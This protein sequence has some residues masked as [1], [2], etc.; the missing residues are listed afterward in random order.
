LYNTNN[1]GVATISQN[2][3]YHY[4]ISRTGGNIYAF[5]NG[6]LENVTANSY[7]ATNTGFYIGCQNGTGQFFT[8]YISN[9]RVI[10][11][12]GLYTANFAPPT[13]PLTPI[14]NT[15][16]LTNQ[17]AELEDTSPNYFNL[18]NTGT[19]LPSPQ[20]PFGNYSIFLNGTSQYLS[21]ASNATLALGSGNF[22]VE[23]WVYINY[24]NAAALPSTAAGIYD[25]R[26]GT[27]GAGVVQ[28]CLELNSTGYVWY[29]T[30]TS[31]IAS[32]TT[33]IGYQRW[34]HIAV[35]RNSGTTNM[36]LDGVQVGSSY[37]DTNN[38][39][40]GSIF[41]GKINDGVTAGYLN[42]YISNV[43]TVIGTAVYTGAFTPPTATLAT[44]QSTGTNIAAITGT[45]T[46]LL[47][48]YAS[49]IFDGSYNANTITNNGTTP[50]VIANIFTGTSTNAMSNASISLNGTSQYLTAPQNTVFAFGTGNFT[51]ETWVFPNGSNYNLGIFHLATASYLP[52]NATGLAVAFL[53]TNTFNVYSDT[54]GG[55]NVTATYSTNTWIHIA[56]VKN[57]NVLTLYV[58]GIGYVVKASD[59]NNYTATYLAIGGYYG[60]S[61]LMT[62]YISNFRVVKGVA[63]YTGAFTP[64][65]VPLTAI[66]GTSL[67][68]CQYNTLYDASANRFTI[69]R[70]GN[71]DMAYVAPF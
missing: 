40:A 68:T 22:T 55:T 63:V 41:L 4:A 59:T 42:G 71:P 1:T 26:N 9:M 58:N 45:A 25:Q 53:G 15:S 44:T 2:T 67:L 18:T 54:G 12:T 24:A 64:S 29:V 50:T 65:V 32:G 66:T 61:N 13:A 11:G 28:P 10:L 47:T 48:C 7:N 56:L 6:A 30:A 31:T 39:P 14:A 17:Y 62:G 8:G 69:T 33:S 20:N 60:T 23:M 46:R 21:I 19:T 3:W 38:Y 57:N 35:V 27:N 34:Q 70:T 52:S 16:L 36:Y 5:V 37:T 49:V 43:R 51:I